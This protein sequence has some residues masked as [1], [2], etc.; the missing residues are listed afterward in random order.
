MEKNTE[1]TE[2]T[3]IKIK[4]KI[5][6]NPIVKLA[7]WFKN[8]R[9]SLKIICFIVASIVLVDIGIGFFLIGSRGKSSVFVED[10]NGGQSSQLISLD[11]GARKG[12]IKGN[13]SADFLFTDEQKKT[14][15]KIYEEFGS[16]GL[17]VRLEIQAEKSAV[18]KPVL[19][20]GFIMQKKEKKSQFPQ[21]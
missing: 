18:E 13:G 8:S 3:K 21:I 11:S 16:C 12:K 5:L 7:I 10:L 14:F 6:E 15:E 19:R 2:I 1:N 20:F 4:E 17:V 9:K